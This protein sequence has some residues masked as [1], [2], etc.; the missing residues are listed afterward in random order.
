MPLSDISYAK[1]SN[2]AVQGEREAR[3]QVAAVEY[4]T[5]KITPDNQ[6]R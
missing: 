2:G 6:A 1:V 5:K 3:H 4:L